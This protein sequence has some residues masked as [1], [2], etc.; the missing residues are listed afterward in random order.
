MD[1]AGSAPRAPP[2]AC[3]YR[4]FLDARGNRCYGYDR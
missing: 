1:V 3:V 2:F 4:V